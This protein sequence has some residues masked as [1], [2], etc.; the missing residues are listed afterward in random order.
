LYVGGKHLDNKY[1]WYPLNISA[2]KIS[3]VPKFA[4]GIRSFNDHKFPTDEHD[5]PSKKWHRHDE[6]S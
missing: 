2:G 5:E 6:F 3:S 1:L 4:R